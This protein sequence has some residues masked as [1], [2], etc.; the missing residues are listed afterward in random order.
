MTTPS[1]ILKSIKSSYP[2]DTCPELSLPTHTHY[3]DSEAEIVHVHKS[4]RAFISA[5]TAT[6]RPDL[7][8]I[9]WQGKVRL[10]NGHIV[11]VLVLVDSG[12]HGNFISETLSKRLGCKVTPL[13]EGS[14]AKLP[15]G[16]IREQMLL[17]IRRQR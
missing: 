3:L 1:G 12:A 7:S 9:L 11:T 10:A 15:D 14:A 17:L 8:P 2:L 4:S 5:L 16:N 13:A 6:P